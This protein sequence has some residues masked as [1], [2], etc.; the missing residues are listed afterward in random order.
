MN[1]SLELASIVA[2]RKRRSTMSPRNSLD[3]QSDLLTQH[4][5][6]NLRI[7]RRN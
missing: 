5:V 6:L 4:V 3:R 1:L 2:D 7:T